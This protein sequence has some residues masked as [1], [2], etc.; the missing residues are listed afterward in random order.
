MTGFSNINKN[1]K[2][3][4]A[5]GLYR[6]RRI[7]SSAQGRELVINGKKLLNFCSNDYLGLANDN[8]IK[9]AFQA[10]VNQWGV[11][12]G[13]SH[14]ISGHTAAH[15]ELEA[16]LAEFT[17]RERS[18]LFTSGYAANIGS[19]NALIGPGD[20]AFEDRLNHASLLDGGRLS[21]ARF[22]RYQHRDLE[23]LNNQL[24]RREK[25]KTR[26][27]VISDGTFSMD[28]SICDIAGTAKIAAKHQAWLMVDEAH[29]LGVTGDSG[30]GLVNPRHFNSN[31]VQILIG[32]L[33][34]AFGTQGGF[35]AGS[36]EL[37]ETI[38]QNA[39]TYIYSTALPASIA[40]ATIESLKI[41]TTETWR[42]EKLQEL[43]RQFREG[44]K[45]IGFDLID[46]STP[47]Q[48]IMI[49]DSKTASK[50]S[51]SLEKNGIFASAI[52][53]PTVPKDSARIRI[54]LTAAHTDKDLQHL[55]NTLEQE[56][57]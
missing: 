55:L 23:D 7:V 10:G 43:I 56:Y 24:K 15:K 35:V 48:P 30:C 20:Y 2:E 17:F 29:S 25:N 32:T 12:S 1:L 37:I 5:S 16:A 54:T 22:S 31:D 40:V 33:G 4:E 34:K 6:H 53:P 46:S 26:K 38:I 39:R 42:R 45:R 57:S 52:R 21:G 18:L 49:G 8:R 51:E 50:L 3:R 9:T 28:G 13:A 19:I 47:I 27:L 36:E 41:V 44:A 14:L 11:G